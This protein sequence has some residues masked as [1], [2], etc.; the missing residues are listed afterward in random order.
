M[1]C[2]FCVTE[3]RANQYPSQKVNTVKYISGDNVYITWKIRINLSGHCFFGIIILLHYFVSCSVI[4]PC[5]K[6]HLL[7]AY[8]HIVIWNR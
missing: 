3:V 2:P 6:H 1:E 8:L 7:L 4:S 5:Y